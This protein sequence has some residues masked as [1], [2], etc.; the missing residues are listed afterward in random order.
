Q[1]IKSMIVVRVLLDRG[2]RYP[3]S[4][5]Q[6]FKKASDRPCVWLWVLMKKAVSP[7]DRARIEQPEPKHLFVQ[8][9]TRKVVVETWVREIVFN[10][11]RV[12]VTRLIVFQVVKMIV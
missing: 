10:E 4:A 8:V 2:F 12:V 5:I 11:L 6:C 9:C 7:A 1:R 3:P